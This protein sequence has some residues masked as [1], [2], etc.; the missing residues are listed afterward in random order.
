M[1]T[2]RSA[3]PSTATGLL[4]NL[5]VEHRRLHGRHQLDPYRHD[6][7]DPAGGRD[8]PQVDHALPTEAPEY[9]GHFGLRAGIIAAYEH[10]MVAFRHQGRID[11]DQVGQRVEG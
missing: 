7:F 9:L 4:C 8:V 10:I 5:E 2:N 3:S 6:H 11:H 1:L